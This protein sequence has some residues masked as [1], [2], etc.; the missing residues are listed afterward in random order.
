MSESAGLDSHAWGIVGHKWAVRLLQRAITTQSI[1]HA[2]LFTGPAG[3]GKMTLAL[4]FAAA[5][6]C[7]EEG[8]IPCGRCRAC[9]LSAAAHHPD[10]YVVESE[11]VGADLKIEQIRELQRQLAVSPVEGRRKVA[12]L[13]R[14]EEA[15]ASAANAL[16]KTLEEPPAYA[17]ILLLAAEGRLLLPT[18]VSRCQHINLRP[19]PADVIRQ[20]LVERGLAEPEQAELLAHLSGGRPGWAIRAVKDK[21]LL[22]RRAQ[23]LDELHSLIGAPVSARLRYA[24]AMARDPVVARETLELWLCWWRDVMMVA[25][26]AEASLTN[27]D[28]YSLLRAHA[29]RFGFARSAATVEAVLAAADRLE[30]NANPRL[31]L[32]VLMLDLPRQ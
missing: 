9:R 17:V 16:L 14:F 1:S 13:N 7:Q 30:R 12:I 18:V 20:A 19:L 24:E 5:L 15:T 6:L 2:Y 8:A 26:G 4:A 21:G 23:L 25:A 3:V 29:D 10:L 32:E 31:T 11:H 27:V 28:R 22:Q